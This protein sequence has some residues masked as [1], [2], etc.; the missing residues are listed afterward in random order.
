MAEA[1]GQG[2][3]AGRSALDGVRQVGRLGDAQA[4]T[5]VVLTEL[6]GLR[7]VQVA[8]WP[9]RDADLAA[10]LAEQSGCAVPDR[11]GTACEAVDRDGRTTRILW[12]GP[13]R[14]WVVSQVA[15]TAD[16]LAGAFDPD[17]AVTLDLSHSRSV[18]RLSGDASRPVL[19]KGLPI[20]TH[21]RTL[22]AGSVVHSAISHMNVTVHRRRQAET[23]G[24][25]LYVFR[26]FAEHFWE[27]LVDA[28]AE[29]GVEVAP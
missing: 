7:I 4:D 17:L 21:P 14:Y 28:G 24:F 13:E 3:G 23:D 18:V 5:P 27:W 8:G 6:A 1:A 15:E 19:A 9:D 26:G 12:I 10:A 2:T 11:A 16:R 29:F 25:D 22:P 20:D